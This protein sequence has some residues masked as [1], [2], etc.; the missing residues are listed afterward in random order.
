MSGEPRT[1]EAFVV[2]V[3]VDGAPLIRD[4]DEAEA[5]LGPVDAVVEG[6]RR[7]YGGSELGLTDLGATLGFDS[8]RAS[9]GFAE[10]LH[11]RVTDAPESSPRAT[12]LQVA[13][14]IDRGPIV[15]QKRQQGPDR[16]TGIAVRTAKKIADAASGGQT[17][18]T[19]RAAEGS[20]QEGL[21]TLGSLGLQGLTESVELFQVVTAPYA[22]RLGHASVSLRPPP[23]PFVGRDSLLDEVEHACASHPIVALVGTAGVGKTRLAIEYA[24]RQHALP[25]AWVDFSAARNRDELV[26]LLGRALLLPLLGG[27]D[28]ETTQQRIAEAFA[29]RPA[30]LYLW[31]NVEQ[32]ADAAGALLNALCLAAP[33]S[34]FLVTSRRRLAL[35]R[36]E[37]IV[38]PPLS[39]PD[40]MELFRAR[41]QL[42]LVAV[43]S[44]ASDLHEVVARLDALPLA[45]ELAA[46][47]LR[48]H[49]LSQ[50]RQRL[51]DRFR[52]LSVRP[53]DERQGT[54][55]GA[56]EW[57]WRLLKEAEQSALAQCAVCG[58]EFDLET[59]E[60]VVRVP[61][62][63]VS[64]LL[65]SLV[66]CS[67]LQTSARAAADAPRFILLESVREFAAKKLVSAER[68][69][70][71][72]R[73]AAHLLPR[74][75]GWVRGLQG[76]ERAHCLADLERH[77]QSLLELFDATRVPAPTVALRIARVLDAAYSVRGPSES[78]LSLLEQAVAVAKREDHSGLLAEMLLLRAMARLSAGRPR[79]ALADLD[80][81]AA[82]KPTPPLLAE[83][84]RSYARC[85]L[86]SSDIAS[87]RAHA[88]RAVVRFRELGDARGQAR[89][90]NNLASVELVDGHLQ[91]ARSL[92]EEALVEHQQQ[93]DARYEAIAHCNLG[94]VLRQLGELAQ[95]GQ[96]YRR[97]LSL[98]ETLDDPY[99]IGGT[100]VQLA[101]VA[102]EQGHFADAARLNQDAI[103]RLIRVGSPI[104]TMLARNNLALLALLHSDPRMAREQVSASLTL[105]EKQ[106]LPAQSG[107]ALVYRALCELA[108]G[109]YV[110]AARDLDGARELLQRT[111]QRD[112][113]LQREL[114]AGAVARTTANSENDSVALEA[115]RREAATA[116]SADVRLL[117]EYLDVSVDTTRSESDRALRVGA[118]GD[119]FQMPGQSV[120]DLQRKA[121]LI[122]LLRALATRRLEAPGQA[123]SQDELVAAVWPGEKVHVEAAANRLYVAIATLR[124][125]G[126]GAAL[127]TRSDGYLLDAGLTLLRAG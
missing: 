28:P 97:A 88:E 81:V 79:E 52:L 99:L 87:A 125:L 94:N 51:D 5:V 98:A 21:Q 102:Q 100:L 83:L 71:V 24:T 49:S 123:M 85:A 59:A 103:E 90:L 126:L 112:L 69:R 20:D 60:A 92:Y 55:W 91:A 110:D 32:V 35:D 108:E 14:G 36:A 3:R 106:T 82:M 68:R 95:A 121:R 63:D 118:A 66:E 104:Q 114:A 101:G 76:R 115:L 119:W 1:E 42:A 31:D 109:H 27:T 43:D 38:V 72:E 57:S 39:T 2:Q 65:E 56:L 78:H 19:A 64:K 37:S 105:D 117:L 124:R 29:V 7:K 89:A 33:S 122:R 23:G 50:L 22:P 4:D 111:G 8:L 84:T 44:D 127:Q 13:V 41:A 67:L 86:D 15:I 53:D 30:M 74:A 17:L 6:L 120:V 73:L 113:I 45:I 61:G 25:V 40:G 34:R 70:A 26:G 46:A 48:T 77:S 12:L 10:E 18:I 47:R 58:F 54:L 80:A 107:Q 75:E 9:L 11:V 116:A 62:N 16:V 93:C 96:S